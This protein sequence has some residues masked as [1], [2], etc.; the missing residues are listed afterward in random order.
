MDGA[1]EDLMDLFSV[2]TIE[3]VQDL[4]DAQEKFKANMPAAQEE[5][6]SILGIQKYI[7]SMSGDI[8]NPYTNTKAEVRDLHVFQGCGY[9]CILLFVYVGFHVLSLFL[10]VLCSF[11][12]RLCLLVFVCVCYFLCL[13]QCS[14]M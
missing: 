11:V 5:Y 6:E 4:K 14:V 7:D 1:K 10:C 3:E 13:C 12:W 2:H 8:V 9:E